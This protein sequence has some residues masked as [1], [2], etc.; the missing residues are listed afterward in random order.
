MKPESSDRATESVE[1][2]E[3]S[4]DFESRSRNRDDLT[5]SQTDKPT[6]L[7]IR[8]L[9]SLGVFVTLVTVVFAQFGRYFYLAEIISNFRAQILAMLIASLAVAILLA[10]PKLSSAC[11]LAILWCSIGVVSTW[12][13]SHQP[14]AGAEKIKVMSFNVWTNNQDPQKAIQQIRD[15][16]PDVLA[17]VEY[18]NDWKRN[19]EVLNADYPHRSLSSRWHGFG[20]AIFSKIP[21]NDTRVHQI[22]AKETD[23]PLL[24][25][26]INVGGQTLR[27]VVLHV[28]SPTNP[29]RL[30]LRNR[31][32][33]EV[34]VLLSAQ[35]EPTVVM[36]DFNCTPWSP[37]LSDFLDTTG[38][39]DSRQGFGYQGSWHSKIPGLRIPIDHAFVSP[40]V[41]VHDRYVA[42]QGGS[43]H[44][45]IVFEISVGEEAIGEKAIGGQE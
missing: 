4:E 11:F 41:H 24:V 19:L 23:N 30:R 13:P 39:R 21:L 15:A 36:G 16:D 18:A 42:G 40:R 31:Q 10:K 27:L 35:T 14:T 33:N 1:V 8:R 3:A 37:F 32:L 20:V 44:F 25:T 6:G 17:V 34:G 38:Y 2:T 45:P 7:W 9:G 28:V 22:T 12:Y 5:N 29:N 43:D 26:N